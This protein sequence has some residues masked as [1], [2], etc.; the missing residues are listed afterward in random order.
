MTQIQ[1]TP[2]ATTAAASEVLTNRTTVRPI[3]FT[4]LVRVETRKMLDTRSGIWLLAGIVALTG[5]VLGWGLVNSGP[6][7]APF[8]FYAVVT[9]QIL[10]LLAPVIA[11]LAMTAEWTQRTALTTF[12]LSPRRLRTLGAKFLA[13][14]GLTV[15]VCA[16][17]TAVAAAVTTL[18][19]LLHHTAPSWAGA[20]EAIRGILIAATLTA[21]TAAAIGTL[22]PITALAVAVYFVLPV[23]FG[24]LADNLLGNARP[25]FDFSA[26]LDRFASTHPLEHLGWTATSLTVWVLVPAAVGIVRAARR[27]IK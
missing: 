7:V 15:A 21:I 22:L 3:P 23:A 11:L 2:P 25:W 10:Q 27:E 12:T 26:V 18:G 6:D 14:M 24:F 4:T 1:S 13:G 8:G 16:A 5:V 19:G 20:G 17:G 9:G